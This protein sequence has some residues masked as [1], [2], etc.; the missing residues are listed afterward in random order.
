MLSFQHVIILRNINILRSF[1]DTKSLKSAVYFT[2][3]ALVW[4]L[5]FQTSKMWHSKVGFQ[6][7]DFILVPFF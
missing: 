6:E 1:F 7:K 5:N 4:M 3:T 2:V